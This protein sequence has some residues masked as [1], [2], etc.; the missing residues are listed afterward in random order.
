VTIERAIIF[1]LGVV[2]GFLYVQVRDLRSRTCEQAAQLPSPPQFR[3]D[4]EAN[5]VWVR[6]A[7]NTTLCVPLPTEPGD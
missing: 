6:A 3:V 7:G 2:I 1:A 4:P 5:C